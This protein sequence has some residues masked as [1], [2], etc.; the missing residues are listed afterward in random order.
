MSRATWGPFLL[1]ALLW[2][3]SFSLIKIAVSG[4]TPSQLVLTRLVL[5]AAILLLFVRLQRVPLPAGRAIWRHVTAMAALGN[6]IPFLLLSYG[7]QSTGAGL[8][9]V[10]IG[11]TPLLTVGVAAAA[12]SDERITRR[13]VI[14]LI[15]GFAGVF[16]VLQPWR[17]GTASL[18][19]TLSCLGAAASYAV[20]FVYARRFLTPREL[21]PL[22]LA[23]A[24]LLV[25][26]FLQLLVTPLLAWR[27]PVLSL[28]VV[29]SLLSL[30]FLS[31]GLAYV[32]NFRLIGEA[33]ATTA[34][35]VNYVVPVFAVLLAAVL[36]GERIGVTLVLGGLLVLGGVAYAE[37]RR[38]GRRHPAE[39]RLGADRDRDPRLGPARACDA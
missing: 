8:A 34:S 29:L 37:D 10:M 26:V 4:V 25:A 36:L 35:A 3:T 30:G 28:P 27:T 11:A 7:E 5:G 31:T 1:L 17:A 13:K 15:V 33:G 23:S 12:L 16:V 14:G 2:G 32:I 20:S 24:Q 18:P 6:V 39:G 21:R 22:A 38:P 19:G 9:G